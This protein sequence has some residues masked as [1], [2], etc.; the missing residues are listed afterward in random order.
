MQVKI[1]RSKFKLIISAAIVISAIYLVFGYYKKERIYSPIDCKGCNV[2]VILVDTL[3]ADRLPA[4]GHTVDTAPFLTSFMQKSVVFDKAFSSSP[5]TAPATAT[6][7]TSLLPSSHGVITGFLATRRM[8]KDGLPIEMNRLPDDVETL[9]EMM[10]RAGYH[11]IGVADNF[12]IGVEMGFDRGFDDFRKLR[13][14]GAAK[15][16]EVAMEFL[17][18]AKD[19]GPFFLYMHYMDPHAPYNQRSPWYEECMVGKDPNVKKDYMLCAYDSEIRY[20][21]DYIKEL[22]TKYNLMDNSII[23]FLS[24]HG[25]EFWEHGARGH[26]K[27]LYTELIHVPFTLYHPKWEGKRIPA[28]VHTMDLLPTLAAILE[29]DAINPWQGENQY[30][31]L[32]N[33]SFPNNRLIY[34]ERL[35]TSHSKVNW[36][37]RSVIKENWHYILKEEPGKILSEELFN[38]DF[39][40]GGFNNLAVQETE[41]KD[42]L[43]SLIAFLPDPQTLE[44]REKVHVDLNP[45]LIDQL[46]TLGYIE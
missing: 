22:F 36:W 16:N 3:R 25:E 46:R 32:I 1:F 35:R 24:D 40:F 38:L 43:D 2:V 37:K 19:N 8:I 17:D 7:F 39:D 18:Q 26:G 4:Y 21:D 28:H 45:D 30:S 6:V 44:Q 9:G 14:R 31:N 13:H 5:W 20:M 11:T 34:G 29:L 42:K 41:V 27:T 12:N 15:M 23:V 33:N 10:K